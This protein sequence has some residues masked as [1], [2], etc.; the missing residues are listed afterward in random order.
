MRK[1]LLMAPLALLAACGGGDTA[2]KAADTATTTDTAAPAP[3]G[4]AM[5]VV[6]DAEN[7]IDWTGTYTGTDA[8]GANVSL[9]L[10][11][12]DTYSWVATPVAPSQGGGNTAEGSFNW[13]RDGSRILLD[14]AAGN[15][16]YAV[17][18]GVLFRL[19]NAEAPITGTMDRATALVRTVSPSG[20]PAPP[21]APTTPAPAPQ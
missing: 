19:P 14:D 7:A 16:V 20:P 3:A 1:L 17:G 4:P 8:S 11:R 9:T 15:A 2:E 5:T 6:A 10:L 18:D 21:A 12:G 13:Y